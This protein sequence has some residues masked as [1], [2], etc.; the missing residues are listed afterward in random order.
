MYIESVPNRKSPPC[1]LLRESYRDHGKVCKRTVCN[2]TDWPPYLVEGLRLALKGKAVSTEDFDIVRSRHHG[3]VAAVLGT[4][5]RVGLDDVLCSRPSR[6]RS[7]VIAMIVARVLAPLSKLATA[8]SLNAATGTSTLGELLDL[9]KADE[10]ELYAALDWLLQRQPHIEKALAQQRL[11]EGAMVLYDV[12]S[13]YFEGDKCQLAKYGYSRDGKR[14]R[15]QIVF[16]LL[17]DAEGCPVAVEVFAGN[18]TDSTTFNAQVEKVRRRFGIE[19]VAWVG[20]RGMITQARIADMKEA[21]GLDW[22]TA[23]EA[24]QIRAL[25]A[26]RSL[27]LSLFDERG[28]VEISDPAYPDERLIA[29]RNPLLAAERAQRREEL[30]V[31]TEQQLDYIVAATQRD[32]RRLTGSD[33]IGLRVGRV[34]G[35]YNV[36][37]HFRLTITDDS[38]RYERDTEKI[39]REAAV[40]GI[41]VIRTSLPAEALSAPQAV[42]TYKSLAQVERA[43]RCLKTISLKV[44]PINHWLNDRVRAHVLLCML[45][46]YVEWHMRR[47]LAPMLFA[48]DDDEAA[49]LDD[50]GVVAPKRPSPRAK[51]KASTKQTA[52]GQPVH[53]FATLLAD[54]TTIVKNTLCWKGPQALTIEK[55]TLPTAVQQRAFELLA[56]KL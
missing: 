20:D 27:Q 34:V 31:A 51:A 44:R 12:T 29:C 41:Y 14:D 36:A 11:A 49:D 7:L 15:P 50:C 26:D 30:L 56:L 33:Q 18:T 38:L 53:S 46:Y 32:K 40:D 25:V 4:L 43:F 13:T 10:N 24:D 37:K 35:K 45:A 22:V 5:R 54:L 28:L 23:L 47:A 16:G 19:H 55:T 52:E 17:C 6:E 8:R 48:D 1:I 39:A 3:H 42:C 9:G 2:L 21:K